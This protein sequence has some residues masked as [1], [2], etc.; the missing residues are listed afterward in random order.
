MLPIFA[1]VAVLWCLG[2]SVAVAQ[3]SRLYRIPNPVPPGIHTAL[4]RRF[5]VLHTSGVDGEL[6]VVVLPDELEVF[7]ALAPNAVLVREGRPLT[8]AAGVD[9]PDA[10]YYTVAE[11]EAEIDSLVAAHPQLAYKVDLTELPGAERTHGGRSIFALKVSDHAG[12]DEDEPAVLIVGQHHARELNSPHMVIGAMRRVLDTYASDPEIRSVVDSKELWFVPMVNPDGVHRVWTVDDF[13]R[14][15]TRANDDG[16]IGVDLNRNYEF[17]W[18]RCGS[19]SSGGSNIY[20]GPEPASEPETK[21]MQALAQ[22]LVPEVYIDFHSSGREVLS[23]YAPCAQVDPAVD[24]LLRGF[25]DDLRAPM[26]YRFRAPSASGEAPEY[27]WARNGTMSFLVEVSTS[28]QPAFSETLA[29]ERDFAW[30]GLRRALTT[31]TPS[32]RGHVHALGGGTPVSAQITL[33]PSPFLEGE[34]TRSRAR[35]GRYASWLPPGTW[36]LR[37][38]APGYHPA[39]RT[40][41][42]GDVSNGPAQIVDVALIPDWPPA[43]LSLRDSPHIGTLLVFEFSSPGDEGLPYA[44]LLSRSSDRGVDVGPR[45]F[46]L[47]PDPL[48]GASLAGSVI[49]GGLGLLGSSALALGVLP[50]PDAASLVGLQLHAAGITVAAGYPGGVKK[51]SNAVVIDIVR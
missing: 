10:G 34:V 7:R 28:F 15:N 40:V 22:R 35:D 11:V 13:W 32:V 37:F 38:E 43:V 14:K 36:Q 50:L 48:L 42:V 44:I 25:A 5:D 39:E 45:V 9:S 8:E 18:G 16:S 21:T 17:L 31:W 29:E 2:C 1:C 49:R 19:S 6:Q 24:Q 51:I 3:V 23:T 47:D 30:P 26:N 41:V 27:H 12:V 46:P 20:R 33:V 4:D